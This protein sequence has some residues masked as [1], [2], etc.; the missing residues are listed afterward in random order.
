MAEYLKVI[1]FVGD[2]GT[3]GRNI[4]VTNGQDLSQVYTKCVQVNGF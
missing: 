2:L 4:S 3:D 1:N